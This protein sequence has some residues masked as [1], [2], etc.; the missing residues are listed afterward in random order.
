[1][2][3]RKDIRIKELEAALAKE[4]EDY[5]HL[6]QRTL[7]MNKKNLDTMKTYET[8]QAAYKAQLERLSLSLKTKEKELQ[9]RENSLLIRERAVTAREARIIQMEKSLNTGINYYQD[10][11]CEIER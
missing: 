4:R 9:D 6:Q 8:I 1:M 5:N 10:R 2:M 3:S 7:E 11:K